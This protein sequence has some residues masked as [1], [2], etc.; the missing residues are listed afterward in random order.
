MRGFLEDA[1]RS[2][3]VS[4][5]LFIHPPPLSASHSFFSHAFSLCLCLAVAP[6]R[7]VRVQR[8]DVTM[9]LSV[10]LLCEH[11]PAGEGVYQGMRSVLRTFEKL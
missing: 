1:I 4:C 7:S 10:T 6:K 8:N 11:E 3:Q 2:P 5:L 9:L